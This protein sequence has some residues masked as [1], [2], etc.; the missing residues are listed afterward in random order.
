VALMV[1]DSSAIIAILRDEPERAVFSRRIEADPVRMI[2]AARRVEAGMVIEA[3]KSDAGRRL[4]DRFLRLTATEIVAVRP[5]QADAA[6]DA[7][8]GSANDG[9]GPR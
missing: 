6:L 2:F 3:R 9:T 1:I 8:A 4:L 7:F 5:A